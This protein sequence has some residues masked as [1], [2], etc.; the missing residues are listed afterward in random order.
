MKSEKGVTLTSLIIYVIIMLVVIGIIS[1]ISKFFYN[2]V[3]EA[4]KRIDPSQEFTRFSSFFLKDINKVSRTVLELSPD[5]DYII[6]PDGAQYTFKNNSVYRGKVKVCEGIKSLKF[7]KE[8][9]GDKKNVIRV[10]YKLTEDAEEKT[11]IFTINN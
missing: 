8:V 2:N 10:V 3:D 5:D 9:N 6:L 4:G 7:E 1:I 11:A